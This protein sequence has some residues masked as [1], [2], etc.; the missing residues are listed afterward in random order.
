MEAVIDLKE[1]KKI[2]K[3][4]MDV[5]NAEES[6]IYPPKGIEV[7]VSDDSINFKSVKKLS[8]SEISRTG[9]VIQI[10]FDSRRA[11]YVKIVAENVGK[12]PDGKPGAGNDAW[13]FVDEIIIE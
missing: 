10:E 3:V 4:T 9:K 2:S 5:F 13:L 12:V 11:R 1:R 6:W 8:L 7:F